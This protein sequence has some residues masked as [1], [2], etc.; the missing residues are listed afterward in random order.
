MEF[1]ILG[2]DLRK[3][4]SMRTQ[5]NTFAFN[6]IDQSTALEYRAGDFFF[7]IEILLVFILFL[8]HYGKVGHFLF[9]FLL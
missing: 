5:V 4:S 2:T 7:E 6:I 3:I 9:F 8:Q 1:A